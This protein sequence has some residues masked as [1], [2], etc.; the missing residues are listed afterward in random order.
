MS[1]QEITTWRQTVAELCTYAPSTNVRDCLRAY[2][3][4]KP[5]TQIRK[6][7]LSNFNK[8]TLGNTYKFLSKG[9]SFSKL[10]KH[11]ITDLLIMKVKN[12]FPDT[13]QICNTE[14]SHSFNSE[15]FLSC[16]SCGQEV[17]KPCY[18]KLLSELN[19]NTDSSSYLT[20][21]F[22]I[23]GIH[24]LCHNCQE[25]NIIRSLYEHTHD[26]DEKSH[27][28]SSENTNEQSV[29][30]GKTTD[31][32]LIVDVTQLTPSAS[33]DNNH[34]HNDIHLNPNV[35]IASPPLQNIEEDPSPASNHRTDFM[36]RKMLQ[37][38]EE[39]SLVVSENSKEQ[40]NLESN[41]GTESTEPIPEKSIP[42][43][44]HYVRGWCKHGIKGK[45]C[46][47][48]HPK[49]CT[50]LLQHGNKLPRGCN[51]GSKCKNFHPRMCSSSIS[52][53][54]CLKPNCSY[55]HVRGTKRENKKV[56]RTSTKIPENRDTEVISQ[57]SKQS[58]NK[59][60]AHDNDPTQDFLKIM[61]NF[62]MEI[63]KLMDVK[64]TSLLSKQLIN[65]GTTNQTQP[66]PTINQ[67]N[68]PQNS[69]PFLPIHYH[70]LLG[71]QQMKY[72]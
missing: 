10:K 64:I 66:N 19:F 28:N 15:V 59:T 22:K 46:P 52:D 35:I 23:P 36:R 25:E 34:I 47:Y 20:D 4:A 16:H 17:H 71:S 48:S 60:S 29:N 40:V 31:E 6:T 62:K 61:H 41:K 72:F 8:E 58:Q 37:E 5:T 67:M 38:R 51:K 55:V 70:P 26:N 24:F 68:Y 53:G 18:Q 9:V 21:I 12:Y 27:S 63:I 11:E 69:V 45:N 50:K 49:A 54:I 2:D 57:H 13:C 7:L 42:T 39:H 30:F 65:T 33:I 44:K 56:D 14:Y 1:E 3:P 32:S 43:C